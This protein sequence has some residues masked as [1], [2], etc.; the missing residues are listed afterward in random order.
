MGIAPWVCLFFGVAAL[1]VDGNLRT[2]KLQGSL[3]HSLAAEGKHV[4]ADSSQDP[5]SGSPQQPG[6]RPPEP[7]QLRLCNAHPAGPVV[8]GLTRT[9]SHRGGYL[10]QGKLVPLATARADLAFSNET[11]LGSLPKPTIWLTDETG[12]V[13]TRACRHLPLTEWEPG[14]YVNL[15]V[16]GIKTGV[17]LPRDFG[18]RDEY[19]RQTVGVERE[20][21]RVLLLAVFSGNDRTDSIDVKIGHYR[22]VREPQ[23][24]TMDL[25]PGCLMRRS[26]TTVRLSRLPPDQALELKLEYDVITG[27]LQLGRYRVDVLKA[28]GSVES[29]AELQ[30]EKDKGYAVLRL[31]DRSVMVYPEAPPPATGAA[32]ASQSGSGGGGNGQSGN[33]YGGAN[34]QNSH[35]GNSAGF[36][37]WCTVAFAIALA[38]PATRLLL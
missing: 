7:L 38:A 14:D 33:R 4:R 3:E 23:M 35:T 28:D 1:Q 20:S 24:A 31:D 29:S 32:G 8:V 27:V 2:S 34:G 30:A 12:P 9:T 6:P 25:E 10:V 37:P 17:F 36:C 13:P 16:G 15:Q 21:S 22:P 11:V 26:D 5:Y 19:G 18:G